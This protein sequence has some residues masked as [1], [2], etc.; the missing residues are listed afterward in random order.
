[1]PEP[2]VVGA[3]ETSSPAVYQHPNFGE[4]R[5]AEVQLPSTRSGE[6]KGS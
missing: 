4:L 5:I 2:N 3:A 6:D 1:M